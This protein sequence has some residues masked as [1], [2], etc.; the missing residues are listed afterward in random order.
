MA[1]HFKPHD[2][3]WQPRPYVA[4][5]LKAALAAIPDTGDWH[6]QLRYWC[7]RELDGLDTPPRPNAEFVPTTVK[8]R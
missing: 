2:E 7:E 4:A 6:G 3:A 8:P 5:N 1:D